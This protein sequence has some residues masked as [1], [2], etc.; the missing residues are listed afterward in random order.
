[1]E[2]VNVDLLRSVDPDDVQVAEVHALVVHE[3]GAGAAFGPHMA[4]L[5]VGGGGGCLCSWS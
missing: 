3:G 5:R 4:P 2:Y 1:M